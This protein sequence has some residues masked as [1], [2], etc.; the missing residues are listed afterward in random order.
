[1]KNEVVERIL[2]LSEELITKIQMKEEVEE[3]L[4]ENMDEDGFNEGEEI[5]AQKGKKQDKYEEEKRKLIH[6]LLSEEFTGQEINTEKGKFYRLEF[7]SEPREIECNYYKNMIKTQVFK[8]KRTVKFFCDKYRARGETIL[9]YIEKGILWLNDI[10]ELAR[11]W[12]LSFKS[13]P[14]NHLYR[15]Q[16]FERIVDKI[17][18]SDMVKVEE[19]RVFFQNFS[20]LQVYTD[21]MDDLLVQELFSETHNSRFDVD[22]KASFMLHFTGLLRERQKTACK[23]RQEEKNRVGLTGKKERSDKGLK[24][25]EKKETN[26]KSDSNRPMVELGALEVR[27]EDGDLLYELGS[28]ELSPEE[29]L[30][31][32]SYS[33][34]IAGIF[35]DY[36]K[37]LDSLGKKA[38]NKKKLS[39][40][41]FTHGLIKAAEQ[42]KKQPMALSMV[43]IILSLEEK[44]WTFIMISY[45]IWLKFGNEEDYPN[46]YSVLIRKVMREGINF[47][48]HASLANIMLSFF[49]EEVGKE[50]TVRKYVEEFQRLSRTVNKYKE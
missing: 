31:K 30:F 26:G 4:E 18:H 19:D 15:K 6:E 25:G 21:L 5:S 27:N 16:I 33:Y 44:I 3:D 23:N 41:A 7:F 29:I 9:D 17:Y 13:N 1:M 49:G 40:A 12:S 50:R 2:A 36:F 42:E 8:T 34:N 14:E 39:M 24:R 28:E 43:K 35:V 22:R 47:G 20:G 32:K 45:V 11:E 10:D 48:E 37:M 46:L 38:E